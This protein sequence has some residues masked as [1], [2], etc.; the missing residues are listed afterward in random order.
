MLDQQN[1]FGQA[2]GYWLNR[3]VLVTGHTG[4]FGSWLAAR[5][6]G[7][8]ADVVGFARVPAASTSLFHLAGLAGNVK[9]RIL[10]LRDRARVE[11]MV[12]AEAAEIVFHLATQKCAG[13]ALKRPLDSFDTNATG[14]LNLLNAVRRTPEVKA[15][16]VVT[17]EAV[18]RPGATCA[19]ESAPIGGDGPVA[20][21]LACAE[22]VV[23][24]FRATYL[25]PIDG[26]G[27]A[28]L[29][30]ST[31]IGGGD[32]TSDNALSRHLRRVAGGSLA[33]LPASPEAFR[34]FLHVLD[35]LKACL[36]LAEALSVQSARFAR[37]WNLGPLDH[38]ACLAAIADRAT[39]APPGEALAGAAPSI[40]SVALAEALGWRPVLDARTAID[41]TIEGHRRLA[42]EAHG[43]FIFRQIDRLATRRTTAREP[44]TMPAV[45]P[46]DG[47]AQL[48]PAAN[49]KASDVFVPA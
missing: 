35:A 37:A 23:E 38:A 2:P 13:A 39:T 1:F 33:A 25:Q 10:D 31:L 21:S 8:G 42:S 14:T 43:R 9:S 16:V 30:P 5:L 40:T 28:T 41:W 6:S 22:I 36:G 34:P 27:L 17:G 7:L 15:V 20:A 45:A 18:Y 4:F 49:A 26:V 47:A 3:R 24:S 29:R 46:A 44:D 12:I 32:S 48:L 19:S 11:Q